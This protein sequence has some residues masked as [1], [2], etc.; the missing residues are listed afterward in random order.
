MQHCICGSC[1]YVNE[2]DYDFCSNCGHPLHNRSGQLT[3]YAV[4]QRQRK[5]LLLKCE[6]NIQVARNTLYILAAIS[7]TGIGFAFSELDEGV[8]LALLSIVSS[9]LFFFLG[10]WSKRRP[11]TALLM[12]IIVI[13]TYALIAILG[14]VQDTFTTVT[15]VYG[16]FITILVLFL[17]LRGLAFAFKA[18]LVK[19][20]MEIM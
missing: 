14:K 4:R 19:E 9:S 11:F 2:L 20:E 12:S 10:K 16:L 6:T 13:L 17:L 7:I 3:L 18:D 5:D 15:G 1:R 8:F